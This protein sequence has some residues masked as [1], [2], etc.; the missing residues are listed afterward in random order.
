MTIALGYLCFHG[1]IVA[2]DTALTVG[3][4]ELQEGRKLDTFICDT[5]SFALVHASS[6]ANATR[7][8]IAQIIEDVESQSPKNYRDVK[9]LFTKAMTEWWQAFGRQKPPDTTL[10]LGAKLVGQEPKLFFCEPPNTML[11]KD[12]YVSAG[13]G[14]S[15]TQPLYDALF[16][17]DGGTYSDVQQILRR[18]AYLIHRAKEGNVYCGKKTNCAVVWRHDYLPSEVEWVDMRRAEKASRE[19]DELFSGV[20][21]FVFGS[22]TTTIEPKAMI[23]MLDQSSAWLKTLPLH[24]QRGDLIMTGGKLT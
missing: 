2:A 18:I 12:D 23:E 20:S 1:V 24:D 14:D 7:T 15:V 6:D 4:G 10:I 16:S 3:D 19:L 17:N 11:E 8:L 21:M 5:G 22:G 13:A 9:K